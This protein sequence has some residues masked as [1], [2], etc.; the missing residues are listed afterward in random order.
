MTLDE[1]VAQLMQMGSHMIVHDGK[2]DLGKMKAICQKN[3]IGFFE[4]ITLTSEE[5]HRIMSEVQHYMIDSTRL[6][7]PVFTITESLHGS[8]N[9]GATIYPQAIALGSTFNPELVYQM[10]RPYLGRIKSAGNYPEP[11]TRCRCLPGFTLGPCGRMFRRRSVSGS[12]DGSPSGERIYG[13]GDFAHAEA[14]WS[15]R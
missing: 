11:D 12:H 3:G 6:G 1:K 7:I 4:G 14:F 2:V 13:S 9:D 5:A 8:V 15:P 10:T